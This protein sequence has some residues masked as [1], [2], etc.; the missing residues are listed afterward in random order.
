MSESTVNGGASAPFDLAASEQALASSSTVVRIAQ[1]R[2][3]DDLLAQNSDKAPIGPI[4]GLLFRTHSYYQ[5]RESRQAVQRC[6]STV[7]SSRTDSKAL[8]P[9]VAALRLES[10]KN[11][12]ALS[13]AFVLAEW[14]GLLLQRLAGSPAWDDLASDILLAD[15]ELLN[16]C[17][18][19]PRKSLAQSA[20][21][22]TRR[23][24]RKLFTPEESRNKSLTQA[25]EILTAKG[26]QPTAKHAPILGVIAGVSSR[27][28][29]SKP[30]LE[31]LKPKY[32]EF[33]VR[34]IV[35]SRV[36]IPE[37]VASGLG[38]FFSDFSKLDEVEKDIIPAI[39]K[40]LLRSPE[41]ILG[42]V[43]KP[44]VLSL[45]QS[46]DLSAILDTKLIKPL[47]SNTKSSNAVI[48]SG[49]V[50]A[51][52]AIVTRSQDLKILEH[53][54]DEIAT[55]LKTGKVTSA[56]HR[57]LHA[58][59][60]EA[61]PLSKT[62]AEKVLVAITTVAAKEGNEAAL[63]A[64]TSVFSRACTSVIANGSELTK[65]VLDVVTK[66]LAE[67]KLPSR[68]LWLLRVGQV[69][70]DLV[71][72]E[73]NAS[74]TSFV[75]AV[76]P[77]LLDTYNEVLSNAQPAAQNGIVAGAYII[78]AL[79]P[80]LQARFPDSPAY[81]A[82]TKAAVPKE[83]LSLGTKSSYLLNQRIYSKITAEDDLRW[84]CAALASIAPSLN[85][86]TDHDVTVAWAEAMI[87]LVG[88]SSVPVKVQ[89]DS[90]AALSRLFANSPSL[91]GKFVTDG[92]WSWLGQSQAKENEAKSGNENLVQVLKSICLEP[93]ELKKLGGD[94]KKEDLE[95]LACALLVLSR[96]ELIPRASWIEL[97]LRMQLDP[98]ELARQ[99]EDDLV[100]EISNRTSPSQKVS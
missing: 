29:A 72:A 9:L 36:A 77:K 5:D 97:C 28:S 15:A 74:A 57:I 47:L 83:A 3:I 13:S 10:Q 26:A 21:V 79:G 18:Q 44:L 19:T 6:L 58:E 38:D 56:D 73:P 71:K 87:Y 16:K 88:V 85:A 95:G 69:L 35:G 33:Y 100:R 45:P 32:Y 68:R 67:K 37:H 59:M 41:V 20:I 23:G 78:T 90:A 12:I 22:V 93:E 34:E 42:G 11:G 55:P 92:L 61:T 40:G 25:V 81:A 53:V 39:E 2:V 50:T 1:L 52:R 98:G 24:F 43:L 84:L 17:L 63:G 4:L 27:L 54:V 91:I 31:S 82:I 66:G 7:A 94:V 76:V 96:R 60:L 51:Y 46:F 48:R 14:C 30:V 86:K 70:R 80:E 99:H 64:E 8:R 89:Q 75:A 65:P 62:S 49:A